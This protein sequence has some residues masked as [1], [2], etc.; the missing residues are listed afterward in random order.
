MIETGLTWGQDSHFY[1]G[2][3]KGGKAGF[4]SFNNAVLPPYLVSFNFCPLDNIQ[5]QVKNIMKI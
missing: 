3:K 2:K 5:K 4:S 1:L